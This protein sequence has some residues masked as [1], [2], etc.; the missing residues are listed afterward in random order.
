MKLQDS[1]NEPVISLSQIYTIAAVCVFL[2]V[3]SFFKYGLPSFEKQVARATSPNSQVNFDSLVTEKEAAYEG[4][5]LD[6]G[7]D[8]L[9]GLDAETNA[10]VAGAETGPLAEM[11]EFDEL[12]SKDQVAMIKVKVIEDISRE[13]VTRYFEELEAVEGVSGYFEL[14]AALSASSTASQQKY[15]ELT[16]RL[17]KSVSAIE[18]PK[19]IAAYH[20]IRL[21]FYQSLSELGPMLAN[22][23]ADGVA[24]RATILFSVNDK[25]EALR[26]QIFDF[27]SIQ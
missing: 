22:Q 21:L 24:E 13:A 7:L 11:P 6:S 16:A 3:L 27:Y 17:I 19:S 26:S 2:L 10:L 5:G 8:E 14:L 18:V 1:K 25:M 15:D 20:R 23:N 9:E 12:A 4:G